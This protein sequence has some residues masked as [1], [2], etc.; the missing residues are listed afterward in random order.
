VAEKGNGAARAV[1]NVAAAG[2][3]T[4]VEGLPTIG[5]GSPGRV[6]RKMMQKKGG[7]GGGDDDED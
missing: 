1:A 3:A 5:G 4:V 6:R 7:D 2:V